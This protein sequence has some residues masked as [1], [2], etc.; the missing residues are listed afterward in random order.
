MSINHGLGSCT[1]EV[2]GVKCTYPG[3]ERGRS[4]VFVDTPAFNHDTKPVAEIGKEIMTWMSKTYDRKNQ[5]A[6]IL[7]LHRISDVRLTESPY[8]HLMMFQK[9]WEGYVLPQRVLLATTMWGQVDPP[10]AHHREEKIRDVWGT[11]IALGSGMT[12]FDHTTESAWK[13]V[14]L[15]LGTSTRDRL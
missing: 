15:L 2:Q 5:V 14:D 10:T 8:A 13:I 4:V 3:D 11:M 1:G 12:R 7:Y 6:G 9:S